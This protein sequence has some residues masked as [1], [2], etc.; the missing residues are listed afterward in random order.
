MLLLCDIDF[1][2]PFHVEFRPRWNW[3]GVQ[4]NKINDD[5]NFDGKIGVVG[6]EFRGEGGGEKTKVDYPWTIDNTSTIVIRGNRFSAFWCVSSGLV[7]FHFIYFVCLFVKRVP[8]Y[9]LFFC[10]FFFSS[11]SLIEGVEPG[12]LL[13]PGFD[14]V[15]SLEI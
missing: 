7:T 15:R 10:F 12:V 13:L 9:F 1:G 3:G 11:V 5:T 14:L 4:K 8:Y 2:H 6:G